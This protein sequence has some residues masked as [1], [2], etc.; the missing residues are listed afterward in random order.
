M[1]NTVTT[2][3]NNNNWFGISNIN[4]TW[5]WLESNLVSTSTLFPP[6]YS[7][8]QIEG[9]KVVGAVRLRQ[10][11]SKPKK[12]SLPN[13]I[14]G[15]EDRVDCLP[16]FFDEGSED[17]SD[18][19]WNLNDTS[20]L[21]L[22]NQDLI[23]N[24][25]IWRP[26][27]G[28]PYTLRFGSYYPGSF[29]IDIDITSRTS[30]QNQ[31]L[32]S[33]LKS[34]DDNGNSWIDMYTRLISVYMTLYNANLNIFSVALL[35]IEIGP[36]NYVEP[37]VNVLCHS[38]FNESGSTYPSIGFE[39]ACFAAIVFLTYQMFTSIM[40]F[41]FFTTLKKLGFWFDMSFC[42]F[43]VVIVT[44]DFIT[45]Q[46]AIDKSIDFSITSTYQSLQSIIDLVEVQTY[47]I[48]VA[49]LWMW[50][51]L[52]RYS[53]LL[54][55]FG[56]VAYAFMNTIKN[57][58]VVSF[59][60]FIAFIIYGFAIGYRISFAAVSFTSTYLDCI[61]LLTEMMMGNWPEEVFSE[62]PSTMRTLFYVSFSLAVPIVLMN[63]FISVFTEVYPVE[64]VRATVQCND[65][66]TKLMQHEYIIGT[67][68]I[69]ETT[70]K[71]FFAAIFHR[72]VVVPIILFGG[73]I[74]RKRYKN[75]NFDTPVK[76]FGWEK[77]R[78]FFYQNVFS[79]NDKRSRQIQ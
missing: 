50:L 63:L 72:H 46:Q 35:D 74:L 43:F 28:N 71:S 55:H 6:V 16:R 68:S 51:R 17:K 7:D 5:S 42:L 18:L 32:I 2:M 69:V 59:L 70:S 38:L 24:S 56:P 61:N 54:P 79:S 62:L 53:V 12:C 75:W 67:H 37:R 58:E 19:A 1:T 48:A 29:Y 8:A 44:L 52:I 73:I 26:E 15:L 13:Y 45:I 49:V 25:R 21:D 3:I 20:S 64:K 23:R 22:I 57:F 65:K 34:F 40:R 60:I 36:T 11:R 77:G 41:G 66:I 78:E 30:A 27:N 39:V 10:I 9:F 47:L 4:D 14:K 33:A 76:E 31:A